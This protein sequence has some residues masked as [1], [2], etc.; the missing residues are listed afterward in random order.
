M[1]V[2]VGKR[3]TGTVTETTDCDGAV[4]ATE[5]VVQDDRLISCPI[6]YGAQDKVV[7]SILAENT[8]NK[9]LRLPAISAYMR[10]IKFKT[11]YFAGMGTERRSSYVP[12]G[13]LVPNDIQVIN[14]LRPTPFEL[15]M[16]LAIYASNTDQ[17]F[18]ILE[19]ILMMFNPTLQI[20]T[21]D[22]PFDMA[23]LTHV[24]LTDIQQEQV[25][26]TSVDRRT[27][28]STLMFNMP[29]YLSAPA[30]IHKDIIEKIYVRIGAVDAGATSS[31]E[32]VAELDDQNLDYQLWVDASNIT[33]V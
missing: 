23:R 14:Q 25:Y 20:Q 32:I 17:Y 21:S 3:K 31:Y 22:S 29:I 18:Q 8:Q 2:M 26:P 27:I 5:P 1:Q 12:V 15:Q 24:E 13:G 7:A 4:V 16:E 33:P 19:Q 10:G 28:Q 9:L 6:H 30:H 11:D